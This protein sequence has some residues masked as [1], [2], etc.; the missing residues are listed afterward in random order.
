MELGEAGAEKGFEGDG[1]RDE[2]LV[3]LGAEEGPVEKEVPG[4]RGAKLED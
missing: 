1:A 4:N 3:D 2:G